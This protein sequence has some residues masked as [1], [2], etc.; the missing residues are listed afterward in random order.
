MSRYNFDIS[1]VSVC[2]IEAF[3]EATADE[4]RVLIAMR[5][6]CGVA[7]IDELSALAGV[8]RARVASGVALWQEAGILIPRA[9]DSAARANTV[10]EEFEER[11]FSGELYEDGGTEVAR[12][13]RDNRL[14]SLMT[15]CASLMGKPM[16]SASEVKRIASL[17]S[18]YSLSEEFIAVLAAHLAAKES[19][20]V[21]R[22]VSRAIKLAEK[23]IDTVEELEVYIEEDARMRGEFS[24][25]RK[26]LGIYNRKLSS[27]EEGY[28][29]KWTQGFGYTTEIIGEAYDITAINTG[30]ASF[31]YMDKLLSDWSTSGCKTVEDC[32]RRYEKSKEERDAL[33]KEKTKDI[34]RKKSAKSTPRYGDFDPEEALKQALQRSFPGK[35]TDTEV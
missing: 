13:I 18:Q 5:E 9:E 34:P 32:R 17:S 23:G 3:S 16:L 4:L 19:L 22:L 33:A 7:E 8:S 24:E 10:T 27:S 31:A 12:S 1:D 21:T 26:M 35:K 11:L 6:L 20:T 30:K 29:R 2:K 14:A 25:V 28:L 15:E